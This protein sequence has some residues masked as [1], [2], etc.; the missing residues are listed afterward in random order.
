MFVF[1]CGNA[2]CTAKGQRVNFIAKWV[3]SGD[4]GVWSGVGPGF[5]FTVY[6]LAFDHNQYLYAGGSFTGICGDIACSTRSPANRAAVWDGQSWFWSNLGLGLDQDV[7]ALAVDRDN[8]LYAGGYF[9]SLCGDVDCHTARATVNQV[10]RWDGNNWSALGSG[11]GPWPFGSIQALALS[12]GNLWVGGDFGT[13][14]DN[15]SANFAR[16][17]YGTYTYL[18]L[19][20]R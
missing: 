19:I 2:D 15:V 18:P 12:H 5:D 16:Y 20:L 8:D 14:G 17:T 1:L 10:A 7:R 11:V 3:P 9:Q 4:S 13:A 6:A